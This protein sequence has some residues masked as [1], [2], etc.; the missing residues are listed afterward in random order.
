MSVSPVARAVL[1][2]VPVFAAAATA[3]A[4]EISAAEYRARLDRIAA[5]VE[6]EDAGA[7]RQDARRL[8]AARVRAG[9]ETLDT[10][11]S[12]LG[13]IASAR[14][15]A[16]AA[17][18][19][20]RLAAL[21]AALGGPGLDARAGVPDPSRL[22]RIRHR[23]EVE[24]PS[25]GGSV[26]GLPPLD[27]RVAEK[28]EPLLQRLGRW[29]GDLLDR[30]W[31]WL[32]GFR[33]R[34]HGGSGGDAGGLRLLTLAIIVGVAGVLAAGAVVVLRRS[35]AKPEADTGRAVAGAPAADEDPLSRSV[36]EWER[37]AAL[38]ASEGRYREA[39]R[40]WY[41]AILMAHFRVGALQ[42][43]K[44][45]TNLEYAFRLP[46]S[47]SWRPTFID[48]TRRFDREWYGLRA[49]TA[50]ALRAFAD[51]SNAVLAAVRA[52]GGAS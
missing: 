39:V 2:A 48:L 49:G 29:L 18:L 50:D 11:A 38:L 5:A 41:H 26:A 31:E 10:D 14:D 8:L 46:P 4:E 32:S 22:D 51:D 40:A 24:K 1:A 45:R 35:R 15:A 36:G 13:P 20:S 25:S 21:R 23:E 28:A 43:Q 27:E 19:G 37:Y 34:S 3:A 12:V 47:A 42:Y 30:L 52:G 33:P 6:A 16:D 44:G 9:A 7:A 17:A